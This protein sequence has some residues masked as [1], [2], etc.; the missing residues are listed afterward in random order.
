VV[1]AGSR[2]GCGQVDAEFPNVTALRLPRNFGKTRARNI[3]VRTAHAE[4]ILFLDPEVEVTPATVMGLATALDADPKCAAVLPRLLDQSG[5]PA[6]VAG[7]LPGRAELAAACE[8]NAPLPLVPAEG[9]AEFASDAALL[10]RK[11]FLR[12]M[13]FLDEKRFSEFWAELELFRRIQNSGKSVLIANETATLHPRR[14]SY[15]IPASELP[16]LAADRVAGAVAYISKGEGWRA[17]FT[18]QAGR[19]FAALGAVL[20]KPGYGLRLALAILSGA[21]VDGTQGGVLG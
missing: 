7:R 9:E 11:T 18:F 10:V 2:D 21:R 8:A 19:F 1:D 16:L 3:G 12:S 5:Q 14:T 13:N 6:P 4:L 20:R 17:G 15:A